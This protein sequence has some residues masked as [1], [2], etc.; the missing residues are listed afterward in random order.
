[1]NLVT[2]SP[3]DGTAAIAHMFRS[4]PDDALGAA[5]RRLDDT[6]LAGFGM[7]MLHSLLGQPASRAIYELATKKPT[8]RAAQVEKASASPRPR[9]PRARPRPAPAEAPP[10]R[11]PKPERT[12][13]PKNALRK[14]PKVDKEADGASERPLTAKQQKVL[15]I[16]TKSDAM[17][18]REIIAKGEMSVGEVRTVL[19]ALREKG[20]IFQAGHAQRSFWSVTQEGADEALEK[21]K[22]GGSEE[23]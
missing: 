16:L 6:E 10:A 19:V 15:K 9:R 1:M 13:A 17:V 3:D 14:I 4:M 23:E 5:V 8:P 21:S 18:P 20:L 11:R 7:I 22:S 12:K 2:H